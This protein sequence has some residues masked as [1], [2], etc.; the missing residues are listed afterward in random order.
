MKPVRQFGKLLATICLLLLTV[1]GTLAIY[2]SNLPAAVRPWAAGI[3]AI[4]SLLSL[5]GK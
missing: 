3:F 4:G 5:V 1:W 2:Y